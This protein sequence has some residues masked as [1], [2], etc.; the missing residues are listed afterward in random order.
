M[1]G[2][3]AVLRLGRDGGAALDHDVDHVLVAGPGCAV[4]RGQPVPRLGLQVRAPLQQQRHHV[5]LAPLGSDV[6]RCYVVL[7]G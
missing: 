1:E 7:G 3:E 4:Q 5:R 2:G 6:K